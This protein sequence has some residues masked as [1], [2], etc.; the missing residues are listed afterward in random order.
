MVQVNELIVEEVV[1]D[2]ILDQEVEWLLGLNDDK[3]LYLE[4]CLN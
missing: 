3:L 1:M 2:K 4:E